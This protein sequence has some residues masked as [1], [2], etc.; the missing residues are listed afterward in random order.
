MSEQKRREPTTVVELLEDINETI[1]E[2]KREQGSGYE[3]C[4]F[5]GEP[6]DEF[7]K[8]TSSLYRGLDERQFIPTETIKEGQIDQF[9]TELKERLANRSDKTSKLPLKREFAKDIKEAQ[10][11]VIGDDMSHGNLRK[12]VLEKLQE[13]DIKNA[14]GWTGSTKGDVEI[15]AE[16]Q[17]YGGETNLIDFSE[18]HLVATFFACNNDN[19][20]D[21]DGRLIIIPKQGIEEISGDK[22]I[23]ENER[24]I[25]RPLPGNRRAFIQRSVMLYE[26][27]GYLEY[28]N[29]R[30]KVINI[31]KN[32]KRDVRNYLDELCDISYR[33]IFPDIQ[34]FIESQKIGRMY[35]TY[36]ARV[37]ALTHEKQQSEALLYSNKVMLLN[38]NAESYTLRAAAYMG[39][40]QFE[41]A[42]LDCE[43]S[44]KL[45]SKFVDTYILRAGIYI[46]LGNYEKAL[47]DCNSAIELNENNPMSFLTRSAV[48]AVIGESDKAQ[49]DRDRALELS[50]E[51][52][53][54]ISNPIKFLN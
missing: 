8:I 50:P 46:R 41:K 47:S 45:N 26:P 30:L 48:Y 9:V 11:K 25:V 14:R 5:R 24:F 12:Y 18:N 53:Q 40:E 39:L 6:S 32:L 19:Y 36:A 13:R 43:E 52:L 49:A 29:K 21:D 7:E 16:I 17:H 27:T 23:P 44:I 35:E 20:S 28:G 37:L 38:K 34:G 1:A 31:P 10:S 2:I 15:L 33:S 42:L 54:K 22:S 3:G 51:I 4:I